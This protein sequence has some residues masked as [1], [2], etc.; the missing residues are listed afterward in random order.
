MIYPKVGDLVAKDIRIAEVLKNYNIDFCCGGGISLERACEKKGLNPEEVMKA[1]DAH[2]AGKE[3]VEDKFGKMSLTELAD[4][5]TNKHH[6]YCRE[7]FDFIDPLLNKVIRV[8]GD[9][10]EELAEVGDLFFA[11]VNE[12]SNHM[13]KEENILFPLI[14]ALEAGKLKEIDPNASVKFPIEK[15]EAEHTEEGDRFKKIKELTN[16][17]T[18]PE[19]ACNTYRLTYYKLK[20]FNDDLEQHIHLENN[21]LFPKSI[22]LESELV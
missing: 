19:D 10:H 2:L 11:T 15:M 14:K 16:N 12:L 7:S 13:K 21:I 17:F 20:E 8:H 1:I 3:P 5:V 4:Y 22:Q 6:Q 18:P 9:K